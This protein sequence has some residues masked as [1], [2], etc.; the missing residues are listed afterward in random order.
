MLVCCTDRPWLAIEMLHLQAV[1]LHLKLSAFFDPPQARTYKQDLQELYSAATNFLEAALRFPSL[2]YVGSYLMQ[3]ILA[4]GF[5][6][7]KLLNSFFARHIDVPEARKLFNATISAIRSISINNNDMPARLAEVLT[8]LWR[9]MGAG[10]RTIP[11]VVDDSLQLQVRCRMSLSV[12]YDS[13]WRWREQFQFQGDGTSA[14]VLDTNNPTDP[15][16]KEEAEG[17]PARDPS[18]GPGPGNVMLPS[19]GNNGGSYYNDTFGD[20]NYE[21]F[22][23]LMSML[24]S[25]FEFPYG[26]ATHDGMNGAGLFS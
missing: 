16:V 10:L 21:V 9:S 22:D 15:N 19:F 5:T 6:L 25:G 20:M 3:I 18:M 7:A 23:P 11:A 14:I 1:G 2:K 26:D 17:T 12:V 13:V 8:Q 4:A 24:D